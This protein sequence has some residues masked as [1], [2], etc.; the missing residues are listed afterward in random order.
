MAIS[1][2]GIQPWTLGGLIRAFFDLAVAYFLL[3]VSTFVFFASKFL[4]A[5]GLYLPCPCTGIFGYRDGNFCWHELLI[6]WPIRKVYAVQMCAK[7]RFPFDLIWFKDSS[8]LISDGNCENGVLEMKGEACSSSY[9]SPRMQN[10]VDRESGFDAKGKRVVNLRQRS[11]IRRRRRASLEYG[12]LSC[13][14]QNDGLRSAVGVSLS[15]CDVS[16]IKD[17]SSES[18]ARLGGRENDPQDSVNTPTGKYRGENTSRSFELSR[19][20]EESKGMDKRSFSFEKYISG[21]QD[22]SPIVGSESDIVRKLERALEEEKAACAALH[23]ELEKERSAAATATDEAMAMICRLQEE[24]ASIEIEARQYQRMIE[25]KFAYDEEEIDIL[26][27]ILLRREKENHFLEKEIEAYKQMSN[28]ENTQSKD[29]VS[30]MLDEWRQTPSPLPDLNANPLPMLQKIVNTKSNCKKMGSNADFPSIFEAPI[31]EK[32]SHSN[33]LGL[34]GKIVLL[35]GKGKEHEDNVMCQGTTS[36][37]SPGC[38]S[39]E[40]TIYCD[41]EGLQ[42]DAKPKDLVDNKLQ[43]SM[44]EDGHVSHVIDGKTEP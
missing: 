4:K 24:K 44:L 8:K 7:S 5:I 26:K 20:Y 21:A 35:V 22:E 16:E 23:L 19:S 17:K 18:L 38:I 41:E 33:G 30:D 6:V 12:K 10:L 28:I 2:Q 31:V 37:A 34:N 36:E 32:Q 3:W 43:G 13:A 11:G 42:Q 39:N 14:F 27:E 9:S 25:E 15:P 29:H 40:K 1:V